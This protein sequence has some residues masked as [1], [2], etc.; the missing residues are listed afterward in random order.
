MKEKL[1]QSVIKK[2]KLALG[3]EIILNN[4]MNNIVVFHI[5]GFDKNEMEANI[6]P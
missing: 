4:I 5:L 2:A 6:L 1:K 3:A